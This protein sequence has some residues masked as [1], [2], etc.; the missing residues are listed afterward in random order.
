M[1]RRYLPESVGESAMQKLTRT[2]LSSAAAGALAAAPAMAQ[3]THPGF[4]PVALH[5]GHAVNKTKPRN[6]G[7]THLTYTFGLYSYQPASAP[8][9]THLF[10]TYYAWLESTLCG[11]PQENKIKAP[12]R[13]IYAKIGT[14]RETYS[15]GCASGPEVFYGDTWTNKTGMSGE[16]DQFVSTLISKFT[17]SGKKYKGT[18]NLDVS[19]FIE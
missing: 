9:K 19:V 8:K 3:P 4:H 2:L 5:A 18:L 17:N 1:A 15:F 13:S 10:Y 12:K 6:Q 11:F 14:A 16:T 7:A